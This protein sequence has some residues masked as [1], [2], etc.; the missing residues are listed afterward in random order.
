MGWGLMVKS[1]SVIGNKKA[2]FSWHVCV[3]VEISISPHTWLLP[4]SSRARVTSLPSHVMLQRVHE[5]NSVSPKARE[6]AGVLR[7]VLW[8][9][10]TSVGKCAARFSGK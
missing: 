10:E 2:A 6:L 8:S 4:P 9:L 7:Y 3:N 5:T 1:R